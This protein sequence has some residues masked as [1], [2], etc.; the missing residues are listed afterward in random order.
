MAEA[1]RIAEAAGADVIDINMGCPAQDVTGGRSG[2]ALMR[3]LDHA[4]TLLEAAVVAAVKVP[5]TVKMRLGWDDARPQRRRPRPPRRS[6]RGAD[7]HGPR[8]DPP[9]ILQGR[10]RLGGVRAVRD[11]MSIR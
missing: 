8:A 5:V 11:A 9:A 7:D 4:V 1:A 2:S 6:G 10:R 3:D